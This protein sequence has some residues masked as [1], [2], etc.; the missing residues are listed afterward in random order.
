MK[1][2][3]S[4]KSDDY[5][6]FMQTS[7]TRNK[8]SFINTGIQLHRCKENL[9]EQNNMRINDIKTEKTS[10]L[11]LEKELKKWA[12]PAFGRKI[13]NVNIIECLSV[14]DL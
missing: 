8:N 6:S 4:I 13:T 3:D 14:E 9:V 5:N 2:V 7:K 11:N 10:L 1:K 12:K